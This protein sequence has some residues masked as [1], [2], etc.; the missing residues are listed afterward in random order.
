MGEFMRGSWM[1]PLIL[2]VGGCSCER[3]PDP[4]MVPAGSDAQVG[5]TPAANEQTVPSTP[6]P[7]A[8]APASSTADAVST[9]HAYLAAVAAKDWPRAD[10]YWSGGKPPPRPDDFSVRGIEDLRSMRINNESPTPLDRES[11]PRSVEIQVTIRVRKETG[12]YEIRGWYRLRRKIGGDGW[13]ITSASM[14]PSMG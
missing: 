13:E 7:S 6:A 10:T 3:R 5:G 1:L 9:V 12:G 4:L 2:L 14:Q 11:P 8:P